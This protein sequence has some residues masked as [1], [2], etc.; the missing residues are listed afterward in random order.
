M[1][2]RMIKGFKKE[3]S[4]TV[5]QLARQS[6]INKAHETILNIAHTQNPG[7]AKSLTNEGQGADDDGDG[8]RN[9]AYT[10]ELPTSVV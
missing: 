6:K 1:K 2:R 3:E 5:K 9:L 4:L 7:A 8:S 10:D